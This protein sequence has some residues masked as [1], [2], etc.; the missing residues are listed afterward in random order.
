MNRTL[1]ALFV[2]LFVAPTL[3]GCLGGDDVEVDDDEGCGEKCDIGGGQLSEDRG[4]ISG[5]VADDAFEAVAGANVTL[6]ELS[7]T[8]KS[9]ASGRYA[10]NDLEPGT[11][12]VFAQKPPT[13]SADSSQV[14]VVGGQVT[15]LD[16]QLEL[17]PPPAQPFYLERDGAGKIGCSV[18][19]GIV[20]GRDLCGETDADAISRFEEDLLPYLTSLVFLLESGDGAVGTAELNVA[21]T[22]PAGAFQDITGPAPLSWTM[23][24]DEETAW[25]S[26]D[27]PPDI[28]FNVRASHNATE[29]QVAYQQNIQYYFGMFYHGEP[30]PDGYSPKGD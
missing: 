24:F 14:E 3:A 22:R 12:T 21:F 20:Q 4:R 9:D 27:D 5:K 25:A 23:H 2:V 28:Q 30:V 26:W 15:D 18:S 6:R 13:H 29:P 1:V 17:L 19:Y 11:Y 8:T 10:F 7:L 16:L